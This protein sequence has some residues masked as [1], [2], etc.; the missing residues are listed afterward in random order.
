MAGLTYTPELYKCGVNYVGVTDIPL[1]FETAPQS[2]ALGLEAMKFMVGDP[3]KPE[4]LAMMK[5]R[6]PINHVQKIQA[7]LLMSCSNTP[8]RWNES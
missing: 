2:W 5:D 1:L 7:P 8:P 6:S 3:D 4:D